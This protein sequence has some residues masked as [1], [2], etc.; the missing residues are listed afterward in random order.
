MSTKKK[1][2]LSAA[3][4]AGGAGLNV[5]EVFSTYLY[6]GDGGTMTITNDIDLATEGGLV[7]EKNR[8]GSTY[9]H[10]FRDNETGADKMMELPNTSGLQNV[11]AGSFTT[12]GYTANA[13]YGATVSSRDYV[14]WTFRKAPKFFDVVTYTGNGTNPRTIN[15]NLGCDVGFIIIKR[16]D[17][18]NN[19][20]VWHR[21]VT[22]Y[23]V[24][25]NTAAWNSSTTLWAS[26][27]PTSTSFTVSNE[28]DVN[29]TNATYVAYLFAH[30]DAD[31]EFGPDADQDIIKCGTYTGNGSDN[32]P[33]INLGFEPQWY[34]FK[35]TSG[36]GG[37]F[38]YDVMRGWCVD[39]GIGPYLSA[40]AQDIEADSSRVQP[41]P[42]GIKIH[43]S[44]DSWNQNGAT[45]IY[46]AIRRGPMAVPE[47]ATD[48]FAVKTST[49]GSGTLPLDIIPSIGFAPD[50][51][52]TIR[53]LL[54]G[55]E[56]SKLP[57]IGT[58]LTGYGRS[59]LTDRTSVEGTATLYAFDTSDAPL[60]GDAGGGNDSGASN[61]HWLWKRAP[62]FCDVV[63][64]TG[65]ATS[66]YEAVDHNLGVIPEMMWIKNRDNNYPQ[67]RGH[68]YVYHKDLASNGYLWL[69]TASAEA[70]D[71]PGWTTSSFPFS[72]TRFWVNKQRLSYTNEKYIAYLFASLDGISKVGSY[73]GNGSSQNI[74]CGFSSGAR[75]VLIKGIDAGSNWHVWDSERGIVSGN[76][77][78]LHLNSDTAQNSSNDYIDPY[79][80]GFTI[81]NYAQANASGQ[82]FIFYAIA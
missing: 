25:N 75:F 80:A 77:P 17:N 29:A 46:M 78:F 13:T 26:T 60:V 22:G 35:K 53:H 16:T 68:W 66:G 20:H 8:S 41:T 3:G 52:F 59:L 64:W 47:S 58:R 42:T 18:T 45:F 67:D 61:I 12:T 32:G 44:N 56:V 5:E 19:W 9:W 36:Y 71:Y 72:A 62:N 7:W 50:W 24:F 57:Y 30:N 10:H 54:N 38:I 48:V 70:T 23:G 15:H 81:N 2:F 1:L 51:G 27:N 28:S 39:P 74:D 37:W 11:G 55:S 63:T 69:D 14:S 31:G 43:D 82:D 34:M 76:D 79:S 73:T 4:A 40:N 6:T 49:A 33:E 21:S 65:T